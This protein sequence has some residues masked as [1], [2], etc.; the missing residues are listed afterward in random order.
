MKKSDDCNIAIFALHNNPF[1]WG[2]DVEEYKPER[3]LGEIQKGSFLPFGLVFESCSLF[4]PK[5]LTL[6]SFANIEEQVEFV[7]VENLQ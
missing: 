6:V 3:F 2:K 5:F 7:L 1:I 4:F